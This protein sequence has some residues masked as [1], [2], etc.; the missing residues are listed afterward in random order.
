MIK[1]VT[2]NKGTF[3]PVGIDLGFNLVLAEQTKKDPNEETETDRS[4]STNGSG[5][6]FLLLICHFC[7]GSKTVAREE[8][9]I[10]ELAGWEFSVTL[11][12]EDCTYEVTRSVDE[13]SRVRVRGDL[14]SWE[15]DPGDVAELGAETFSIAVEAWSKALG[16][17]VYDLDEKDE[18]KG[19]PTFGTLFRY[20]IRRGVG[21]F[22]DP[23]R[24]FVRQSNSVRDVSNAVFLGIDWQPFR[25]GRRLLNDEKVVKE[26]RGVRLRLDSETSDAPLDIDKLQGELENV[27]RR[28]ARLEQ[29]SR[30]FTVHPEYPKI[31]K[32]VTELGTTIRERSLENVSLREALGAY[33]KAIE[34]AAGTGVEEVQRIYTETGVDFPEQVRRRLAEAEEFASRLVENR[35][36]YLGQEIERLKEEISDLEVEIGRLDKLRVEAIGAID[37]SGSAEQL[38]KIRRQ[39]SELIELRGGLETQIDELQGYQRELDRLDVALA[40][41]KAKAQAHFDGARA[42]VG[43]IV[44]L[45]EEFTE[46][47]LGIPGRLRI[48]VGKGGV[49][50]LE[51]R[52]GPKK[53]QGMGELLVFCYDLAL[54]VAGAERG[55]G[56]RLLFHDSTV[57]DGVDPRQKAKAIELAIEQSRI[58]EFRYLL[59]INEG[60]VPWDYLD[61]EGLRGFLRGKITDKGDGGLLGM[62]FG[63]PQEET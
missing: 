2:A 52:F 45:F 54:A 42:S 1:A 32:R 26:A 62:R 61:G 24:S 31:E 41:N 58:H 21:A 12:V 33:Q 37:G 36:E 44:K 22:L 30:D 23:F 28:L 17:K 39:E 49:L 11:E 10:Q 35:R 34:N 29:R 5:K 14:K 56:P 46:R 9:A 20:A 27:E 63:E 57:F 53:S 48:E 8:F 38:S 15:L 50:L 3:K 25:E 43:R 55:F 51:P 13:P 59:C 19:R 7:L 4:K 40:N 16:S 47:V 6:T 60:D 18:S